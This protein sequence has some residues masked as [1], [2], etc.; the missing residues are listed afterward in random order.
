[1]H[2]GLWKL[3]EISGDV[4]LTNATGASGSLAAQAAWY[5][6]C[7]SIS[8]PLLHPMKGKQHILFQAEKKRF[9]LLAQMLSEVLKDI[10][11]GVSFSAVMINGDVLH[12]KAINKSVRKLRSIFRLQISWPFLKRYDTLNGI[13]Y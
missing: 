8:K 2:H 6:G 7:S 10:C 11:L 1:M 9:I 3:H 12:N 4:C 5:V 13:A